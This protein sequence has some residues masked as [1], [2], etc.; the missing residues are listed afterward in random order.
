MDIYANQKFIGA[1][2]RKLRLVADMVRKMSPQKALLTLDFTSRYAAS[3]LSKAIKVALAN[4]RQQGL[5]QEK[6]TFKKIEINEGPKM[7]RYRAGTRGRAKPY[8]KK[9]SHIKIILTDE[10][11]KL[12]SDKRE[13]KI[14]EDQTVSE[15]KDKTEPAVSKPESTK[16]G[17]LK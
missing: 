4:A 11:L 5:D 1:T 7:K 9:M 12:I 2:P 17:I 6:L 16:K 10:K 13:V 15:A 8:V 3:D 14:K